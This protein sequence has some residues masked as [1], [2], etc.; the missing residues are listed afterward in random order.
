MAR[1]VNFRGPSHQHSHT[2]LSQWMPMNGLKPLK[3]TSSCAVQQQRDGFVHLTLARGTCIWLVGCICWCTWGARQYKLA[4]IQDCILFASCTPRH[5]KN[6]EG[7]ISRLEARVYVCERVR[8]SFH[9]TIPLR[10]WWRGHGWN[11]TGQFSEWTGLCARSSWFQE[12][13]WMVNKALVLENHR[14]AMER[15]RKQERQH[16]SSSKSRLWIGSSS[17]GP[18]FHPVQQQQQQITQFQPRFQLAGQGF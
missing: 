16:Q 1:L 3:K 4:R 11:E 15:K 17:A 6:E 10:P 5:Y 13:P 12:F 8:Y 18:V 7:R 2:R 14:G 9:S